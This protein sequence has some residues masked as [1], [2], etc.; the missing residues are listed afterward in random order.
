MCWPAAWRSRPAGPTP[1][2]GISATRKRQPS[3]PSCSIAGRPRQIVSAGLG[4][5]TEGVAW[6]VGQGLGPA[7][8]GKCRAELRGP[9]VSAA[10][11]RN[12]ALEA[13][14]GFSRQATDALMGIDAA[15]ALQRL[16]SAVPW[17]RRASCV[18]TPPRPPRGR[19]SATA[20]MPSGSSG[21]GPRPAAEPARCWATPR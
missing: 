20:A 13:V 8:L 2:C 11:Y 21:V 14:G 17:N 16:G 1:R 4:Y 3:R 6:R 7:E 15:L 12:S 5:R 19:A 18:P 9:D 10:F